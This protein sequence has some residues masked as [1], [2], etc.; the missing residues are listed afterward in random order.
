MNKVT[1]G[2]RFKPQANTWNSFI[3]AAVY[4]KQRQADLSSQTPNR[5]T[6]SGVVLVR[7][8]TDQDLAQFTVVS[9]GDLV[10]KPEDNEQE[11]RN[12]LPIFELIMDEI[13]NPFGILQRPIK[14][15]HCGLAMI[16]G[17]TPVKINVESEE[18][19]FAELDE[20][21][22]KSSDSGSIRILWK[23]SGTDGNKWAVILL[24]ASSAG[25]IYDGYFAVTNASEEETQK[26]KVTAGYALIN[27]TLFEVPEMEIPITGVSYLY[28]KSTYDGEN[29]GAPVLES[30]SEF[31]APE[32]GTFKGLIAI[33][34]WDE[35][36]L[37]ITKI[38]Q[39]Q[40]GV[41]YG[42]IWGEC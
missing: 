13:S 28:L 5:D 42:I 33:I 35:E 15:N 26:V 19:E 11:F 18:H 6:K 32:S 36:N 20:D 27:G 23:E 34:D 41:M 17:I 25:F 4:V 38:T 1:T 24:G 3:D 40:F 2:Q 21:G 31:P 7:N 37:K 30:A 29:V 10:I 16:S 39:Q 8:G 14:K 22:L 12:N 9:L